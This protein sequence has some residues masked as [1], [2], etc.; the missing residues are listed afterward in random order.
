VKNIVYQ[1]KINDLQQLQ[2][3]IKGAAATVT[4]NMFQATWNEV[5]YRLHNNRV[6]KKANT[7]IYCQSYVLRKNFD[8]FPL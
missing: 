5:E 4:Q 1:D 3:C 8:S 2:A 6:T 7:E